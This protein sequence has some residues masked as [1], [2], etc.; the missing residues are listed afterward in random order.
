MAKITSDVPVIGAS[1]CKK[2][3]ETEPK[4]LAT[5]E[6]KKGCAFATLHSLHSLQISLDPKHAEYLASLQ[7]FFWMKIHN[8]PKQY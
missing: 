7:L 8:A 5:R 1:E 3:L 6:E 2:S 4:R